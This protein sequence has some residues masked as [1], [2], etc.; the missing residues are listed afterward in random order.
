MGRRSSS[1]K[2]AGR[3]GSSTMILFVLIFGMVSLMVDVANEGTRSVVGPYLTILGASA[4]TISIV[5][6]LG[7]LIGYG[8]RIVFGWIAD[9]RGHYWIFVF[10]GYGINVVAVPALALAGDWTT[11]V[12][13]IMVERL[14][15]AIR[16]PA[17]EAMIS[18]AGSS[19][20]RG[21]SYG[22]Q[23]ALSSVGGMIGPIVMVLVLLFDGDYRLGFEVMLIPALAAMVLLIYAWKVNPTPGDV[24]GRCPVKEKRRKFPVPFWLFLLA[25][26]L[27]A[28]GYA[29]YP[30]IAFHVS[31]FGGVSEGWVP[32]MY[33]VAM[34]ADAMSALVFGRLYDRIGM[35][36]LV[37]A[38]AIVPFFVPLIFSSDFNVVL[39]GFLLYGIGFGAQES[40]MRAVVADLSPSCRKGLAFG[41]YNAA[42]GLSWFLG[43]VAVGILYDIS[44]P[45]M[46]LLSMSLQFAAVPLL[47]FVMRGQSRAGP[48]FNR[49]RY[50]RLPAIQALVRRAP[51]E[52]IVFVLNVQPSMVKE[53]TPPSKRIE[54][55]LCAPMGNIQ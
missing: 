14:G 9:E 44:L 34:A 50:G 54:P 36:P 26:A 49:A 52:N 25:G 32:I 42:F 31:T 33:A 35:G 41:S 4:V 8:L 39:I 3:R 46:V 19:V 48:T 18:H 5:S 16:G 21:W 13:L 10:V 28:A 29:D 24:R 11:A 55:Q 47:A 53:T 7:E 12:I 6:G 40:V 22:I 43:S 2:A 27:I 51:V 30:L 1:S 23:E 45:A 38:S 15:R 17:R 37:I 20:G